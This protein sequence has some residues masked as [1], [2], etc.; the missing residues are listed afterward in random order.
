MQQ[1]EIGGKVYPVL[2]SM[3][4]F[5]V[6]EKQY[7]ETYTN[8]LAK[9]SN[10]SITIEDRLRILVCAINSAQWKLDATAQAITVDSILDDALDSPTIAKEIDELF[11][12]ST[13][14][15]SLIGENT[16]PEEGNQQAP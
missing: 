9:Y 13:F 4:A 5:Y 8:L 12:E 3:R 2:F 11:L 10:A 16:E 14:A 15:K 1:I 7:K 6:Y